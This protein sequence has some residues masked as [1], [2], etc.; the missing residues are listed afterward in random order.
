MSAKA[1]RAKK[2]HKMVARKVQ[3]EADVAERALAKTIGGASFKNSEPVDVVVA[4]DTG[5]VVHGIEHKYMFDNSNHK[6]TMNKYAQVRKL[7][8][9]KKNDTTFHTVV[10]SKSGKIFYRRGVG[11]FRVGAM[12]EVKGGTKEL[13]GLLDIPDNELPDSA[14]RTDG[15]NRIGTWRP[16]KDGKGYKNSKTG[17]IAKPKK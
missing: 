9:E 3:R 12:Y 10:E 17:D 11:S 13:K 8:W 1:K 2:S 16:I 6:I 7:I 15:K 4:D 14:K 5:R